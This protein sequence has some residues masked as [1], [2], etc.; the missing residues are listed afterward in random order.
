VRKFL[1]FLSLWAGLTAGV[2]AAETF[3]LTDGTSM[4]G[5]ISKADDYDVMIHTT[6]DTF[7]NIQWPRF[8]Q[9]TLKELAG[10]PKYAAWAGP[11][12]QPTAAGQAASQN[13]TIKPVT[14]MTLPEHPSVFGGMVSSSLGLFLLL[15]VYAA[16]LYAAF[17]VAV[18]RGKPIG[19]VMGLSAVLPIIGPII[20]LAQPMKSQNAEEAPPEEVPPGAPPPP[21]A[22]PAPGQ[23]D[24]QIVSASWQPSQ[25]EK[26]PQP[27]VFSRGKFTLNKRFIET[28]FAGFIGEPKGDAKNFTMEIKTLKETLAVEC[29]K[30]IGPTEAILETPNGQLTVPFADIQEIKLIP[31]PA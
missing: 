17:E 28:K 10:N 20:F 16:N 30:Q 23:E 26:K 4:A 9:D 15:I 3:T 18:V 27:Q 24:I 22:A 2:Y 13:I 5:D 29:I 31:K 12:I 8:S 1:I 21:G 14:R 25:E 11:F 7:T 19:A 6:S